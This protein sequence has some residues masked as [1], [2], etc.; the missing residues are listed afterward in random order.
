VGGGGAEGGGAE[1][2][3]GRGWRGG[4]RGWREGAEG[5]GDSLFIG[6][7]ICGERKHS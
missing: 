3:G 2:G 4:G 1:G 5:G 7:R 6:L